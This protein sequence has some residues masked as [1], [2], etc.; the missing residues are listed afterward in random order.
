M[1]A[2]IEKQLRRCARQAQKA[3]RYP[4]VQAPSCASS[5]CSS[6][7]QYLGLLDRSSAG[8]GAGRGRRGRETSGA[9][10]RRAAGGARLSAERPRG[11]EDEKQRRPRR[12]ARSRSTSQLSL[13]EQELE[14][15]RAS[16][17]RSR[18]ARRSTERA[19]ARWRRRLEL[20]RRERAGRDGA[21][22]LSRGH[23]DDQAAPEAAEEQLCA[24]LARD[25]GRAARGRSRAPRAVGVAAPGSRTTARDLRQPGAAPR[26][27][28]DARAEAPRGRGTSWKPRARRSRGSATS[29]PRSCGGAEQRRE[30]HAT[31]R[32]LRGASRAGARSSATP[33]PMLIELR[34]ELAD[35]RSRLTSLLE[36]A[37]ELRRLRAAA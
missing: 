27:L 24:A 23:G 11:L 36:I 34:E 10:A 22:A 32:A 12:A 8:A 33:R 35:R 17:R 15:G 14:F 29:W 20:P 37:E 6:C 26:R 21:A 30:L 5:S 9:A 1:V 31:S 28:A 16:A 4:R 13:G 2:E 25:P 19:I 18:R 7:R 3:E